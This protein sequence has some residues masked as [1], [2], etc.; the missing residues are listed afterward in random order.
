M[1]IIV[2]ACASVALLGGCSSSMSGLDGGS[3]FACKAPPGV[4][5]QSISGTYHN[6]L[7]NNLPSQRSE[8]AEG[9]H[10]E[11]SGRGGIRK[12]GDPDDRPRLSPKDMDSMSSGIPIREP[13]LVLR[14][15]M[16]PWKDDGDDLYDQS[17]FYTVVH[18]GRWVIEATRSNI[19]N[20]FRPVYPLNRSGEKTNANPPDEKTP[21][22][23]KTDYQGLIEKPNQN[24]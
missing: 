14:I 16:A 21:L 22:V 8:Y 4:A 7:Q 10:V 24:Q 6:S 15:W 23:N 9:V 1:K 3:S 2:A 5:C 13:P 19:T 11:D 20:R 18:N 12:Y 17:Y